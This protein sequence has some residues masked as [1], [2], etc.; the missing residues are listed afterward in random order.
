MEIKT[1]YSIG[2]EVYCCIMSQRYEYDVVL[3]H[4]DSI[5]LLHN[6]QVKYHVKENEWAWY[7]QKEVFSKKESAEKYM[8]R[9]RIK[10]NKSELQGLRNTAV[11]MKSSLVNLIRTS[12]D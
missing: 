12:V 8:I 5:K 1:K 7:S 11:I 2:E 6:G 4:I 10:R 9:Y 3:C